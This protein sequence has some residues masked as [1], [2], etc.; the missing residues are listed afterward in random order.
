MFAYNYI[1]YTVPGIMGSRLKVM[2]NAPSTSFATE[3]CET[4]RNFK[5]LWISLW[6][7]TVHNVCAKR[8]LP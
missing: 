7:L 8:E 5:E 4:G 6:R 1:L 2:D 3:F